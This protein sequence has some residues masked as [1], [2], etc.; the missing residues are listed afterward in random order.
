MI[1]K[2]HH[3]FITDITQIIYRNIQ[4]HN[5]LNSKISKINSNQNYKSDREYM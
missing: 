2:S 3:K 4:I 1:T 5:H